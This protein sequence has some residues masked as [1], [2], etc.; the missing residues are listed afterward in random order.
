MPKK[1]VIF[2]MG[3]TG[4]GKT[5]VS[6]YLAKKLKAEVLNCDSM[7]IYKYMDICTSKPS[8][9]L[10]RTIPH[11]LFDIISPSATYSAFKYAVAA[12]R[13]IKEILKRDKM[14][15]F[16]GGSGLY[17]KAVID[18]LFADKKA[19]FKLRKSLNR[20]TEVSLLKRLRKVDP[21]SAKTIH[22]HNK[23][24]LIRAL[25]IYYKNKKP[26]SY[27]K[28]KTESIE[29]KYIIKIFVLNMERQNLYKRIDRRVDEM[30]RKGLLSEVKKLRLKKISKTARAALGVKEL[31]AYLKGEITLDEARR[32]IKRNSRRYAKR[33]LS[34][35]RKDKRIHW[36][37]V[38]PN[39]KIQSITK[40]IIKGVP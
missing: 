2:L 35:F 29:N 38:L 25:E 27:L 24:R 20:L 17:M 11:H 8:K 39:E 14:P 31:L 16:V 32:L 36:I 13:K 12:R 23:R 18:G 9:K 30:F 37:E 28:K 40:K 1:K 26:F 15:L 34:W 10:R 4:I 6:L 5:E 22:P 21:E 3:P 7:Q 33:Q 19:D